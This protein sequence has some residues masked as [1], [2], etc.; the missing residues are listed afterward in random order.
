MARVTRET[1]A[2]MALAALR[3]DILERRLLP[4]DPLREEAVAKDL[5]VSR[6]TVRE[7]FKTLLAEGL[8][9]RN[10]NTRVLEGTH[11]VADDV[12]EI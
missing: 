11:L 9:A 8:L 12:R 4:G 6:P 3:S 1:V 10:S 7:V 2:D 5:G